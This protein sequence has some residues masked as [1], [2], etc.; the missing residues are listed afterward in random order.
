MINATGTNHVYCSALN[1]MINEITNAINMPRV[2]PNVMYVELFLSILC[3]LNNTSISYIKINGYKQPFIYNWYSD[4]MKK[5]KGAVMITT[6]IFDLDGTLVN[7]LEDLANTTNL[8]LQQYGYKIHSLEK[9]KHFVGDGIDR[10]LQRAFNTQNLGF[11]KQVRI[12]F[13]ALYQ[14][15]YMDNTRPYEGI[16]ELLRE[17]QDKDMKLAVVTNKA[18]DMAVTIVEYLFPNTFT[19]IYGNSKKFAHKPNPEIVYHV[20][21]ELHS[22]KEE[23]VFIGDSDVDMHTGKNAAIKTIG[24]AWGFRGEE[25]L[26]KN[27]ANAIADKAKEIGEI[28]NDWS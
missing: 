28:I 1:R 19:C 3:H 25:E 7:S 23:C 21:E 13:D 14:Q 17:L 26:M 27:G 10:L 2:V 9:Y 6:C 8:L 11:I 22:K 15:Q 18:H 12:E 5:C 24:V 4:I 20:L 16:K